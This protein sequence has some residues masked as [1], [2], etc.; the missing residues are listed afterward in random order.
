MDIAAFVGRGGLREFERCFSI[1]AQVRV[2]AT[3]IGVRIG[4]RRQILLEQWNGGPA[5][6]FW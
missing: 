3:E 4:L 5:A 6:A 2:S 1:L